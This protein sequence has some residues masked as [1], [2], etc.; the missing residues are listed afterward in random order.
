MYISL[1]PSP[2]HQP[3]FPGALHG[4][5]PGRAAVAAPGGAEAARHRDRAG[6][7]R[8]AGT[9]LGVTGAAVEAM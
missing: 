4:L 5:R 7:A 1:L 3:T 9:A 6:L 8:G 2:F